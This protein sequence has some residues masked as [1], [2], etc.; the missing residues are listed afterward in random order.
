MLKQFTGARRV[1]NYL[2][3]ICHMLHISYR[4]SFQ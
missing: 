1:H 2:V 3:F 4:E